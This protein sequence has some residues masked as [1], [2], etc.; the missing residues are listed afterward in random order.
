MLMWLKLRVVPLALLVMAA[1]FISLSCSDHKDEREGQDEIAKG[2]MQGGK[3]IAEYQKYLD[4]NDTSYYLDSACLSQINRAFNNVM[5]SI[6]SGRY[7]ESGFVFTPGNAVDRYSRKNSGE[8]KWIVFEV[9]S[10]DQ[11]GDTLVRG[12]YYQYD[13]VEDCLRPCF[14]RENGVLEVDSTS[15]FIPRYRELR[16]NCFFR[17][18]DTTLKPGY[19]VLLERRQGG[20]SD[21]PKNQ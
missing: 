8:K 6:D 4:P 1:V 13:Q 7:A 15:F 12:T 5:W 10:V 21:R 19:W 17:M 3:Y 9:V 16:N 18:R 14:A 20:V 2:P 11:T